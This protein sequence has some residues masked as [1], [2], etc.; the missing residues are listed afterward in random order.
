MKTPTLS[1]VMGNYNH[2]HYLVES[3][4]AILN[5]SFRPKEFIIIDDASTDNSVE[6]IEGFAKQDS[7]VRFYKND[8]NLGNAPTYTK[9]YEL[10]TGD[11]FILTAADDVVLP[12]LF[13]KSMAMLA[14]FP[15]AGFCSAISRKIDGDGNE[16]VTSPE[17]P[18]I[19]KIP[20]YLSPEKA[21]EYSL[22][23][24]GWCMPSTA[25][26]RQSAVLESGGIP[27]E[28]GEF[29]DGFLIPLISLNYGACFI[30]EPL[31]LYRVLSE[32]R[33]SQFRKDPQALKE[34]VEHITKLMKSN[35][36]ANK[37]PES[38]MVDFQKQMLY[39]QGAMALQKW[40]VST[41][42][43]HIFIGKTILN[44]S[45]LGRFVLRGSKILSGIQ[46]G[47]LKL[48]L[49]GKLRRFSWLMIHR[50]F[51]RLVRNIRSSGNNL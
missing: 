36:Y 24:E 7:V 5:Q 20:C 22:E 11:Y 46:H 8:K 37:F 41:S 50:L 31:G 18:Y 1:V 34:R 32:S 25:I 17:P 21:L 33:A 47:V 10:V 13:E 29:A 48:Y 51:L 2:A 27:W 45:L 26:W 39:Q 23:G 12:G 9:A 14:K 6:I 43:C 35:S 40:Q 4:P 19:S 16:L 3:I 28:A 30:P 42:E 49:Y 15:S 38:Y 44:F